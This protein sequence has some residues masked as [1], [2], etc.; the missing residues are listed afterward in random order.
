MFAINTNPGD[1]GFMWRMQ[2]GR[3]LSQLDN[4][5]RYKLSIG[6]KLDQEKRQDIEDNIH[7]YADADQFRI[8]H[9]KGRFRGLISA[10]IFTAV[11]FN[12]Q[13]GG[14]NGKKAIGANPLL[15]S[16]VFGGSLITFY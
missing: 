8:Y 14:R 2:G 5:H 7:L 16:L 4:L 6:N 12:I 3:S 9:A 1:N 11:L 15:A 10:S 13:N